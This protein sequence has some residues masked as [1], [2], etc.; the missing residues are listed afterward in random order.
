MPDNASTKVNWEGKVL[1]IQP[2]TRVWRYL[3]DNRT[4]YHLGFNLFIEGCSDEGKNQ[5]VVAISEKQLLKGLFR[6]GDAIK[7][8]AWTKQYEEREFADYY[9]AGSLKLINRAEGELETRKAPWIMMPPQMHVYELRG[10]RLL[11]KKL[12]E[13]KC[14]KCIWAN[15][16]NV[17]VQW[18]FDR[19]VK[20]YR[21][22]TFCYGP[23]SCRL[24]KMG[25]GRSVAYKNRGSVID[26]GTLD[27]H[28][29]ADR[30]EDD[31]NWE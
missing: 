15:M 17:E 26:D 11:S 5:F 20:K 16:A 6:I 24:Y 9:R 22:E 27:E 3:T 25:R 13:T 14:F 28:C 7:G 12:W 31:E 19:E 10:A 18:D 1:S 29:T 2:R 23:T 30:G 21:F 8:T 4:H